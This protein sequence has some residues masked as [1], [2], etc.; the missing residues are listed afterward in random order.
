MSEEEAQYN[1]GGEVYGV[2]LTAA[3]MESATKILQE[4]PVDQPTV[5]VIGTLDEGETKVVKPDWTAAGAITLSG[6]TLQ[7]LEKIGINVVDNPEEYI[8]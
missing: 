8:F 5:R 3:D 4:A 7:A 6:R 2:D 1:P